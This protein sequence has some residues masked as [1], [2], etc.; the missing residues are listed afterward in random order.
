MPRRF[1][2]KFAFKRHHMSEQWFMSPFRH[3]LHDHRLWGI[4]RHQ[5]LLREAGYQGRVTSGRSAKLSVR[6]A[7]LHRHLRGAYKLA[8]QPAY[9]RTFVL[10]L[11]M[12]LF[13]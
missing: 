13:T 5:S 6:E 10:S 3:L 4:R 8:R 11:Q 12:P 9:P 7:E 2:R 1:F